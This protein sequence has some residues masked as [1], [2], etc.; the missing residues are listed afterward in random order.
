[1]SDLFDK[2]AEEWDSNE[3][4][5]ILSSAVG[6]SIIK[7]IP[8]HNQ[9]NIMDF[10][11]GTG[12]ISSQIAPLVKKITAVDISEAMLK[13]L[14]SKSEL[15][16]K[17]EMLCQNIIDIPINKKFDLIISVMA[18]HHVKDTNKL[19]QRFSESLNSGALIALA[20]LDKEDGTFHPQNTKGIFHL[21]FKRDEFKN[22]LQ[23]QG[24]INISFSTAHTVKKEGKEF[25]IF[26]VSAIKS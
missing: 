22:I 1:M 13:Q 11:A 4:I 8:L 14:V 25:P 24:F 23:K 12:L 26:L 7:N 18:I 20:D 10:G 9:M 6:S 3:I 15:N 19:I 16:S 21:G 17:V 2:K 5:K